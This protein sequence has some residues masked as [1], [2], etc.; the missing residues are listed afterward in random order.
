MNF[1]S[2]N[3]MQFP[4]IF[5]ALQKA[6]N[7]EYEDKYKYLFKGF[8]N[9]GNY[10][11]IISWLQATLCIETFIESISDM[12][13]P[14][15]STILIQNI[16]NDLKLSKNH[17]IKLTNFVKNWNCWNGFCKLPSID[18]NGTLEPQDVTEFH[19][20][21][22]DSLD[23]S[24]QK[25]VQIRIEKIIQRNPGSLSQNID[26]S[27]M[28]ILNIESGDVRA[29]IAQYFE[30]ETTSLY[31]MEKK[32]IKFPKMLCLSLERVKPGGIKFLQT[33]TIPTWLDLTPY[34][35]DFADGSSTYELRS[36]CF[37][38]GDHTENGHWK[39]LKKVFGHYKLCD[40]KKIEVLDLDPTA[41][42]KNMLKNFEESILRN[43][44]F[45]I[46]QETDNEQFDNAQFSLT[47]RSLMS[48]HQT[49]VFMSA[50][51][52]ESFEIVPHLHSERPIEIEKNF[53]SLCGKLYV[54][55][56]EIP[57]KVINTPTESDWKLFTS[58]IKAG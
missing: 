23:P 58:F 9:S 4:D 38:V 26:V 47:N 25:I 45:I 52:S 43:A 46:Y 13:E 22:I 29:S 10:C 1:S 37:H 41:K 34:G 27:S 19:T 20:A 16:I 53:S 2:L 36:I 39:T 44:S 31:E 55:G 28:L 56:G 54:R 18:S 5:K 49:Q 11:F 50:K 17:Y 42:K 12:Q 51:E 30:K 35:A 3:I 7:V 15:E 8:I 33:V 24:I 21:I 14:Q 48:L 40:D 6:D 32:I 57:P